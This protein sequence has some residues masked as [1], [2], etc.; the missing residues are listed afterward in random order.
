M[1]HLLLFTGRPRVG[2]QS[3]NDPGLI[4][5]RIDAEVAELFDW[6]NQIGSNGFGKFNDQKRRCRDSPTPEPDKECSTSEKG[7][8]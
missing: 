2:G 4:H 8:R 7:D 3:Q 1:N 6:S 5:S